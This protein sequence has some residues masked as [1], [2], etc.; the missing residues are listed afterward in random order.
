MGGCC[1]TGVIPKVCAAQKHVWDSRVVTRGV[2]SVWSYLPQ[3]NSY[4]HRHIQ[5]SVCMAGE[6]LSGA[7]VQH[8]GKL[9]GVWLADL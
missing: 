1:K 5:T 9:Q 3:E 7:A 8:A 6:K 4:K 2:S